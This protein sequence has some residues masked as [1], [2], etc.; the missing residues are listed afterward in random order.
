MGQLD[1]TAFFL[2]LLEAF[3]DPGAL[4]GNPHTPLRRRP[5]GVTP[6]SQNVA[7]SPL[8]G[9]ASFV[10]ALIQVNGA[11]PPGLEPAAVLTAL[12]LHVL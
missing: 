9:A 5:S 12:A 6:I 11:A 1:P 7:K 3:S 8:R 2:T 4:S 10:A